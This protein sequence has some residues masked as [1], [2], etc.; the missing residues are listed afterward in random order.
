MPTET[1][2]Y[3]ALVIALAI[4]GAATAIAAWKL[5]AAIR[6]AD[7]LLRHLERLDDIQST[8]AQIATTDEGLDLRRIEHVLIDI[9]DH[10]KRLE[11]R[12]LQIAEARAR[13]PLSGASESRALVPTSSDSGGALADRVVTRLLALG[14]ERVVLVTPTSELGGIVRDGGAVVVEA[15]RDGA[16]CK[17]RVLVHDG[18]IADVQLQSAYSAFP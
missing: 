11:E 18:R 13:D 8:L 14:Y 2:L 5:V 9:R 6:R 3:E 7:T 12:L 15:K 16:A 10:H 17:G 1:L 4:L